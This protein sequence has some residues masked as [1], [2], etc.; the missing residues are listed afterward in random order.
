MPFKE[1][2][3][4]D[5][6][7]FSGIFSSFLGGTSYVLKTQEGKP[8]KWIEFIAH[9]FASGG[10][11]WLAYELLKYG[12]F[13]PEFCAISSGWAGWLGTR[14]ARLGEVLIMKRT[15]LTK[16]DFK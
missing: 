10:M 6:L 5:Y 7:A 2:T 12:G 1:F 14:F 9:T 16:D 13:S 4:A 15:G 3:S 11:G 8:F